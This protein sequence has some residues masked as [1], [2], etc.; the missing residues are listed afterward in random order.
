MQQHKFAVLLLTSVLGIAA[1]RASTLEA[2][3]TPVIFLSGLIPL[4][5]YH[6]LLWRDARQLAKQDPPK[7]L[8]PITVDSVYYF[9][10]IITII[11]L[12]SAII[13]LKS[14]GSDAE[15]ATAIGHMVTLFGL[16]LLATAYSLLARTHLETLATTDADVDPVALAE[17]Y[18][19]KAQAVAER[20]AVSAVAFETFAVTIMEKNRMIVEA[21]TQTLAQNSGAVAKHLQEELTAIFG[22]TRRA[23][24]SFSQDLRDL[25]LGQEINTLRT[26][27]QSLNKSITSVSMQIATLQESIQGITN[28][29]TDLSDSSQAIH[30][31]FDQSLPILTDAFLQ[32]KGCVENAKTVMPPLMAQLERLQA[33]LA[34]TSKDMDRT[35][36][37]TVDNL[38][39]SAAAAETA[40][41]V[42]TKGLTEVADY[43]IT[44]TQ[45]PNRP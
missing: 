15:K 32:L 4:A 45:P 1:A 17:N 28:S 19:R 5:L 18:A 42:L 14:D 7:S 40:T 8:S 26:N 35:Y 33:T 6:L 3:A 10:F 12:A 30:G 36:R 2:T 31:T 38:T 27:L 11:T 39:R 9:G 44:R 22:E 13:L 37:E 43:I 24:E 34:T 20:I 23:L 16:G 29:F 21:C 41:T 25:T